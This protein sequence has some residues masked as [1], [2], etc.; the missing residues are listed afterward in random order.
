MRRPY[1]ERRNRTFGR[2]RR[3]LRRP[4]PGGIHGGDGEAR[5]ASDEP[6]GN[7]RKAFRG[8]CR[9]QMDRQFPLPFA[10]GHRLHAPSDGRDEASVA[11]SGACDGPRRADEGLSRRRPLLLEYRSDVVDRR[12]S[13]SLCRNRQGRTADSGRT[14]RRNQHRCPAGQYPDGHLPSGGADAH[15]RRRAPWR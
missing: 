6:S 2:R 11:Q 4:F 12:V 7:R 14:R 8:A 10:S 13:R 1:V 15:V 5:R 3:V 9:P